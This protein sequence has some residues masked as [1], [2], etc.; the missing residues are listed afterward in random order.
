MWVNL[1]LQRCVGYI[2]TLPHRFLFPPVTEIAVMIDH[3]QAHQ[4]GKTSL[5]ISR[6]SI[7]MLREPQKYGMKVLKQVWTNQKSFIERRSMKTGCSID[8]ASNFPG[9]LEL[10]NGW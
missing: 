6:N 8:D 10:I 7:V 3:L 1:Q 4:P 5:Y 9:L 2:G